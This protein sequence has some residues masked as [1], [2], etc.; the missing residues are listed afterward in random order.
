MS[1]D[2]R[3]DRTSATP[4]F[5]QLEEQ[6]ILGI[7]Q[8]LLKPGDQL[9]SQ[10]ELARTCK[11]SRAT[12][13]RAIDRLMLEELVYYQ[14]GKGI[15]VAAPV[16]QQHLSILH[17]IDKSLGERG[18]RVVS[19]LLLRE[20]IAVTQSVADML[21]LRADAPVLRIK[22]LQYVDD[23]P[24]TLQEAFLGAERFAGLMDQDLRRQPLM[25]AMQAVSDVVVAE[26]A[27]ALGARDANWEDSRLFG[28][29][30]GSSLLTIEQVHYE[31]GEVPVLYSRNSLQSSRFQVMLDTS[32]Q[33]KVRLVYRLQPGSVSI[34][35]T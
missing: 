11:V 29:Q 26:T 9:P 32:P 17:C 33:N 25:Q 5:R 4:I 27:L 2:I 34:D 12:I 28:V 3:I 16:Q 14:Q 19:D 18:H 10:Y 6:I 1:Y 15:F 35:L 8:G 13:Q 30:A 22:R 21:G 7:E 23:E 31:A 24:M 20:E